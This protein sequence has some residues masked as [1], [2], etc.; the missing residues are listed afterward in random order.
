MKLDHVINSLREWK[1]V[2]EE[3]D[4]DGWKDEKAIRCIE[5]AIKELNRY[6]LEKK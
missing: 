3:Q 4:N 1:R 6:Y 2:F 5:K